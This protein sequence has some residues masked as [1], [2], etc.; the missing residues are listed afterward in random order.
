MFG[1]TPMRNAP[2]W[3]IN[4]INFE[5]N[6]TY[7]ENNNLISI[8]KPDGSVTTNTYDN[9]QRLVSTV[10]RDSENN[11]ISGY[12]YSYDNLDR[13]LQEM[14]L[15]D[16]TRI[17]YTYDN[18]SRVTNR[19]V[20]DSLDEILSSEDYEYDDYGNIISANNTAIT[21][22]LDGNMLSDGTLSY[23][24]DSQ[25]RLTSAGNVSY[26]YNAENVRIKKINGNDYIKY[27]Y[28][29]VAELSRLL[30][31]E[32]QDGN[33]TKYIYGVGLIG[34]IV[35]D[36]ISVYHYDYRGSTVAI[37][38]AGGSITDTFEYDTYG[39]FLSRTGTTDIPFMY[40]GRYGVIT[41]ENGLL[42]MR[43]RYYNPDLQR[44]VNADI[45]IG[46]VTD[47]ATL[48]RY[49]YANGNPVSN[50]DPFGLSAERSK[51]NYHAS[52]LKEINGLGLKTDGEI[53]FGINATNEDIYALM[54]IS[55]MTKSDVSNSEIQKFVSNYVYSK[56]GKTV[57]VEGKTLDYYTNFEDITESLTKLMIRN[58]YMYTTYYSGDELKSLADN[59][60]AW[61]TK[62]IEFKNNVG[63]NQ[64]WDLKQ[65]VE[66][67]N[68]SLYYFDGELVDSDAPG[69]IMYGYMGKAYGIP[70]SVLY[71][72]AGAAQIIAGTSTRLWIEIGTGDDP[73]DYYN[74]K[75][76]IDYYNKIH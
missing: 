73:I 76:G 60:L 33:V 45:L 51:T 74:I 65:K 72:A 10:D 8:N 9:G 32:D 64:I 31:S 23:T 63:N 58:E 3:L 6:Y 24:Y 25:N 40:N 54:L 67:Q 29:T 41:D 43:A 56:N 52:P 21:Y 68:S 11:I 44:F 22:D 47:F 62:L 2:G 49:A 27:T 1:P 5:T 53:L 13:I 16:N 12:E 50:V 37:T 46:D 39:K 36:E 71:Y 57:I 38:D 14:N 7:D 28:D 18:L 48:N 66:W 69:N 26:L 34:Q 15:A 19:T 55:E 20:Y 61:V 35:D 42:Y 70:D 59:P 4:Y 30:Y 17:C 75:R